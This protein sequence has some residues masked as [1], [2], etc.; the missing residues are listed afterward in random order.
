MN[1]LCAVFS[2]HGQ[3]LCVCVPFVATSAENAPEKC[4]E[5]FTPRCFKK[6][7]AVRCK[8]HGG[9]VWGGVVEGVRLCIRRF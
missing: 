1:R 4:P 5:T 8:H 6:T 2:F 7:A 3:L 9:Y